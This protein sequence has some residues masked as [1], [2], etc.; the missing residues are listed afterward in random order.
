MLKYL[1]VTGCAIFVAVFA[2]VLLKG[3]GAEK[4]QWIQLFN[5]KNLEGWDLK[6][7]GI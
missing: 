7:K 2:F 1:I 3:E 4:D 6:N 5:G